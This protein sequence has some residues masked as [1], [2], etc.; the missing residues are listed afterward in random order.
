[1]PSRMIR[2]ELIATQSHPKKNKLS[3]GGEGL[4]Q[5]L[6]SGE[7]GGGGVVK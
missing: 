2:F 5:G 1:M 6:G 4:E 7:G 3:A